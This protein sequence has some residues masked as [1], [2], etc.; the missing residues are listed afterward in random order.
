M[1]TRGEMVVC[2]YHKVKTYHWLTQM[3]VRH[4]L[5]F[6]RSVKSKIKNFIQR[7]LHSLTAA[8]RLVHICSCRVDSCKI[9]CVTVFAWK[10]DKKDKTLFIDVL[11]YG[12][13]GYFFLFVITFYVIGIILNGVGV[14]YRTKQTCFFLRISHW[15]I[16][17]S[18]S[19][20]EHGFFSPCSLALF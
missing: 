15:I 13:V 11:P 17:I 3:C 14:K 6:E 16:F 4:V 1:F 8:W 7:C 18:M 20:R 2:L 12:L 5:I 10:S 9:A 19:E